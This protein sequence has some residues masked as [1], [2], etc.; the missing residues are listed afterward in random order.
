MTLTGDT[1]K[2]TQALQ[3]R[4]EPLADAETLVH[5]HPRWQQPWLPPDR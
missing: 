1:M 5:G 3:R 2:P 4:S